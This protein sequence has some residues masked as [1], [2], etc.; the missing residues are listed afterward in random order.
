MGIVEVVCR[1]PTTVRNRAY[2]LGENVTVTRFKPVK[3]KR[4]EYDAALARGDIR[5]CDVLTVRDIA[6]PKV[7]AKAKSKA[8]AKWKGSG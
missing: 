2:G 7:A 6:A 3:M 5:K 4:E 8:K 1:R